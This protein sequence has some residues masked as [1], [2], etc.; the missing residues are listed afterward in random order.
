MS[1]FSWHFLD[2]SNIIYKNEWCLLVWRLTRRLYFFTRKGFPLI[3]LGIVDQ[4]PPSIVRDFI[5]SVGFKTQTYK[6]LHSTTKVATKNMLTTQICLSRFRYL[7]CSIRVGLEQFFLSK[8]FANA[9]S[10]HNGY[11]ILLAKYGEAN[12]HAII[13]VFVKLF[14]TIS[15]NRCIQLRPAMPRKMIDWQLF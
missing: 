1:I 6:K 7:Q 10:C 13:V 5:G 2:T 14:N 3:N 12:A 4:V 9:M 15:F 8:T 11:A